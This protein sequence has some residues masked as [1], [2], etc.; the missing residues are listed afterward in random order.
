MRYNEAN[1]FFRSRMAGCVVLFFTRLSTAFQM[2]E[3]F[4]FPSFKSFEVIFGSLGLVYVMM[5][6][7]SSLARF[8][9]LYVDM[10]FTSDS[11]YF[12]SERTRKFKTRIRNVKKYPI[13]DKINVTF[14]RCA[15]EQSSAVHFTLTCQCFSL[16]NKNKIHF[17]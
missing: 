16:I 4:F 12:G 11:S 7:W 8:N 2:K 13:H 17:Y 3:Y 5:F 10:K 9:V 15:S 6:G 14:K 1:W